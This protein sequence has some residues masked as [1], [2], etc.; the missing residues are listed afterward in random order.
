MS[1]HTLPPEVEEALDTLYEFGFDNESDRDKYDRH[2]TAGAWRQHHDDARATLR[3][4][5]IAQ[6]GELEWL[7]DYAEGLKLGASIV[8]RKRDRYKAIAQ[9]FGLRLDEAYGAPP[10]AAFE[11]AMRDE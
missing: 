1:E 11:E 4:H 8:R 3:A 6:A 9:G 2:R 7:E 10:G 5:L